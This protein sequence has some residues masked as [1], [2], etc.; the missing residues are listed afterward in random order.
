MSDYEYE[1]APYEPGIDTGSIGRDQY[2]YDPQAIADAAAESVH[3]AYYPVIAG[4][5]N[6]LSNV[7][8]LTA[9]QLAARDMAAEQQQAAA[10]EQLVAEA[11]DIARQR[12][13]QAYKPGWFDRNRENIRQE[14]DARPGLLPDASL[15]ETP[16]QI[17]DGIEMAARKLYSEAVAEHQRQR[18]ERN[19]AE[20]AEMKGALDKTHSIRIVKQQLQGGR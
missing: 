15:G 4:Y 7:E 17:A 14:L 1:E 2:G 11:V 16:A 5:E 13:D 3:Q 19:A 8:Q 9:A 20:I 6:R 12:L 18:D 10:D